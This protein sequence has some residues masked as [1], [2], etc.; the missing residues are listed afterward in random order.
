MA[1]STWLV[2]MA[3]STN[4]MPKIWVSLFENISPG[5]V[6]I[7]YYYKWPLPV[8]A[9][10]SKGAPRRVA[11]LDPFTHFHISFTGIISS[12][13]PGLKLFLQQKNM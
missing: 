10:W 7:N 3:I 9:F 5:L 13:A 1:T 11:N 4:H 8:L 2:K 12:N 6:I